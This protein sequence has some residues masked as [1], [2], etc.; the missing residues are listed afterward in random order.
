MTIFLLFI[1]VMDKHRPYLD[2]F[3]FVFFTQNPTNELQS[4]FVAVIRRPP[5]TS[6]TKPPE[7]VFMEVL[8]ALALCSASV[9]LPTCQELF[10]GCCQLDAQPH[11][12]YTVFH[13]GWSPP[14][15][16]HH[17]G[18]NFVGRETWIVSRSWFGVSR[19]CACIH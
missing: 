17:L 11:R 1:S 16:V 6:G 2:G 18:F 3:G 4:A 7:H 19:I 15:C 9:P 8:F 12:R 5:E 10:P 13:L 14:M